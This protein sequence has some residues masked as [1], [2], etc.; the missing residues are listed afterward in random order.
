MAV[1][2]IKSCFQIF[3]TDMIMLEYTP[4]VLDEKD[5]FMKDIHLTQFTQRLPLKLSVQ[6]NV[7]WMSC[8]DK[9]EVETLGT[10]TG[11]DKC[12]YDFN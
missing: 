2:S 10:L 12:K 9:Q 4:N 3:R 11:Y 7:T 1:A 5:G 6:F 8:E